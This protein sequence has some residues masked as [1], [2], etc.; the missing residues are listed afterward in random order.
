MQIKKE[1]MLLV[2]LFSLTKSIIKKSV[3]LHIDVFV[4]LIFEC[5]L[6][7]LECDKLEIS[8]LSSYASISLLTLSKLIGLLTKYKAKKPV[9]VI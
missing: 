6:S 8:Q 2:N 7:Q 1:V 9:V 4:C 5:F 3:K